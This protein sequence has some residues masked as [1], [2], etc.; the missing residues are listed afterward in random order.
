MAPRILTSVPSGK[1]DRARLK[2]ESRI[3]V[4]TRMSEAKQ[5]LA[6]ENV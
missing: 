3:R 6:I 1:T 5:E 2:S 4:A